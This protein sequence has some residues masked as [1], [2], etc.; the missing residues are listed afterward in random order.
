MFSRCGSGSGT[1]KRRSDVVQAIE[2]LS[3]ALS[4]RVVATS[5]AHTLSSHSPNKVI[6]NRS[7]CYKQL[8]ELRNLKLQ[9]HCQKKSMPQREKL[10]WPVWSH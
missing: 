7:K 4:P 5:T 6:E 1:V 3:D 10:L 8:A 9:E 2:K